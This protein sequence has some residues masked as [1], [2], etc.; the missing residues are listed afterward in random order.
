M[1]RG[2][3]DIMFGQINPHFD[4]L[5]AI[6][7]YEGRPT[8]VDV[9]LRP[10]TQIIVASE[11]KTYDKLGGFYVFLMKPIH[12]IV[13]RILMRHMVSALIQQDEKIMVSEAQ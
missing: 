1:R 7:L 9:S 13:K 10:T 11:F 2:D 3:Q 4:W 6:S 12:R 5:T 8:N